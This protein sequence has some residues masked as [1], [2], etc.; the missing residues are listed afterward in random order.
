VCLTSQPD[1]LERARRARAR[2]TRGPDP[3][4]QQ[5]LLELQAAVMA[6]GGLADRQRGAVCTALA[7]A[8]KDLVDGADEHL[9]LLNV[10]AALQ[11][12]LC[13]A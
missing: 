12:T 7:V 3:Q 11:R 10:A 6:A 5:V 4:A 2:P 9:Q 13:S 8:D 1:L